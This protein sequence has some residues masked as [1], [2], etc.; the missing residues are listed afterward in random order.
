[1]GR[2]TVLNIIYLEYENESEYI[3]KKISSKHYYDTS[4]YEKNDELEGYYNEQQY[5]HLIESIQNL[6]VHFTEDTETN[7]AT[8]NIEE[9]NIMPVYDTIID[10]NLDQLLMGLE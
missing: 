6:N 7:I 2:K 8:N 10:L 5:Y 1:M 4:D 9:L 3:E